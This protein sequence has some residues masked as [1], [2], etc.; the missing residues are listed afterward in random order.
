MGCLGFMDSFF[1]LLRDK[2]AKKSIYYGT[3]S[4]FSAGMILFSWMI[5]SVQRFTGSDSYLGIILAICASLFFG[6]WFGLFGAINSYFLKK[7]EINQSL[8]PLIAIAA[9]WALLEFV[10]SLIPV[11]IPWFYYSS[12]LSQATNPYSI[13]IMGITGFIGISF[14]IALVNIFL[15]EFIAKRELRY[16]YS[17]L[18]L[19]V[20]YFF[21]NFVLLNI[22]DDANIPK[23]KFSMLQENLK[24]EM[25]WDPA[26]GDSLANNFFSLAQRAAK[27]NPDFILWS[28]GAIPWEFTPN[29][30]LFQEILRITYSTKATHIFGSNWRAKG[31][32]KG[33][34]NS[35]FLSEYDGKITG[36]YDKIDLLSAVE[37]PLID[38][39]LFD[40]VKLNFFSAGIND[41][42]V[43]G[44]NRRIFRNKSI[45]IAPLVCNESLGK[46]P[47]LEGVEM[48][49]NIL[50]NLSNDAWMDD[51]ILPYHH[52]YMALLRTVENNRYMVLNSNR[53]YSGIIDNKG[54][55]RVISR[56]ETGE[57]ISGLAGIISEDSVY[58]KVGDIPFIVLLLIPLI[59][60]MKMKDITKTKKMRRMREQ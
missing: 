16:L 17:G 20:G 19:F 60:V 7:R 39:E 23:A 30:H 43:K 15:T 2:T 51:S 47:A 37:K 10:R 26:T 50:I 57:T 38:F 52:F 14:A 6:L 8:V 27:E 13:Q 44:E 34:Y 53:G 41:S 21:L 46:A 24:A 33:Y 22:G 32:K 42:I 12:V 3:I 11:D 5:S 40:W 9:S 36:R 29:D 31:K 45:N 55:V 25:R 58:C 48:G 18:G 49:G 56:N 1:Y 35:L 4:G 59:I 28:E 54:R